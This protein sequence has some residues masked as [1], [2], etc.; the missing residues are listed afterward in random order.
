M[1]KQSYGE[2]V[3]EL[4]STIELDPWAK[5]E[6]LNSFSSFYSNKYK[7]LEEESDE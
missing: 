3:D 4:N 5:S 7:N 1:L 6:G 2:L